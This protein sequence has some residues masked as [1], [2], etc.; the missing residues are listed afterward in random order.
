MLLLWLNKVGFRKARVVDENTTSLEEQRSTDWM[1][2]HSLANFL[3]PADRSRTIEG[4]PAPR[5][6]I[7]V[8]EAP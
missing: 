4:Y 5:R 8:A 6:A 1:R 3:D 7:V 2:F